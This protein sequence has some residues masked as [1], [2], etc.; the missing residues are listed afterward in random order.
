MLSKPSSRWWD[1]NGA[2]PSAEPTPA[3]SSLGSASSEAE[4]LVCELASSHTAVSVMRIYLVIAWHR[5]AGGKLTSCEIAVRSDEEL[6][7]VSDRV[8]EL[9]KQGY[10]SV[11][12]MEKA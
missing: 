4:R 11:D 8:E 3:T 5:N 9:L 7:K 1:A 12:V 6:F 10:H 2:G